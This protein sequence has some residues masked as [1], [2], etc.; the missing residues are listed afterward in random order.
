MKKEIYPANKEYFERLIPFAQKIISICKENKIDCVIHGS[1]AHFYYTKDTS[2]NVNDIDLLIPKKDFQKIFIILKRKIKAEIVLDGGTIVLKQG[3]LIVELDESKVMN[4]DN[5]QIYFY[6]IEVKMIGL[7]GLEAVY[8]VAFEESSRNKGKV[9]EN[10]ISLERFLG[11][12][13]KGFNMNNKKVCAEIYK[14]LHTVPEVLAIFNNGAAAV[15]READ[16][17]DIDFVIVVKKEEDER[18]VREIFRKKYKILKNEEDPEISVEEQYEVL[19]KRV[20]PTIISKKDIE[21]KVDGFYSSIENYLNYQHFIKHK[22]VD[23]IAIYDF[24]RLLPMWKTEVQRYP[25]NFMK[26]VFDSQISSVKENLFYWKNHKF[27][28]EFQFGF[29]QWDLIKGICQALY[30]K[31]NH[32]FMLPYKRLA[33]DLKEL[34]PNIEKEMYELIRGRNTPEMIKQKIRIV[35]KILSKLEK[36]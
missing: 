26:E 30:A 21:I 36:S 6:G 5:S 28:N 17:S 35:E 15:G 29:E 34:K 32:L 7:M 22:I 27:R 10:I 8:P 23:S 25:K 4:K 14:T 24:G 16:G 31:N 3:N 12:G 18:K 33:K 13:I 20:D 2:L 11:R 19:R 9:L 1:F